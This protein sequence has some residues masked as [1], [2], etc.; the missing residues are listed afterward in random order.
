M[1]LVRSAALTKTHNAQQLLRHC[2]G[3]WGER[4]IN[5]LIFLLSWASVAVYTLL[6]ADVIPVFL[7]YYVATDNSFV[8]MLIS[9][10]GVVVFLSILLIPMSLPRSMNGLAKFSSLALAFI[11]FICICI[12]TIGPTLDAADLGSGPIVLININGL[13]TAISVLSF[14]FV[15]HHSLL[16]VCAFLTSRTITK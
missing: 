15:C 3:I 9:R 7:R 11:V 14:A 5:L 2:F 16:L 6:M 10:R 12:L 13:H 8:K 1:T 4:F